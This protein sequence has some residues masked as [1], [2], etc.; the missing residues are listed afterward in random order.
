MPVS[1]SEGEDKVGVDGGG[2]GPSPVVNDIVGV[3]KV[4]VLV[5]YP[6]EKVMFNVKQN[7]YVVFP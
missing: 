6:R 3:V 4:S 2:G 5:T 7:V 1:P